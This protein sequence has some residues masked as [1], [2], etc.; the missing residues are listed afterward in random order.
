MLN[1]SI[2]SHFLPS[3][4]FNPGL[5]EFFFIEDRLLKLGTYVYY[6]KSY[7]YKNLLNFKIY[8]NFRFFFIFGFI[9][10]RLCICIRPDYYN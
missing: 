10:F 3:K 5:T 7:T 2:F 1:F 6:E 9:G 4:I 8:P